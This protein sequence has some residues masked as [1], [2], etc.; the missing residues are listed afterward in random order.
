MQREKGKRNDG[1][2]KYND[3]IKKNTINKVREAISILNEE[4]SVINPKKL[5]EITGLCRAT[6]NSDH[7]K[8]LME[9]YKDNR[10]INDNNPKSYLK[11]LEKDNEHLVKDNEKL[12]KELIKRDRKSVV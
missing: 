6:F 10:R 11:K 12:S 1:L 3:D 9:K 4:R 7:V 8:K 5:M 2:K